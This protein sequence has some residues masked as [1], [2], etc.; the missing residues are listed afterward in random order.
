M[1][2]ERAATPNEQNYPPGIMIRKRD[3]LVVMLP[4]FEFC[5]LGIEQQLKHFILLTILL[6]ELNKMKLVLFATNA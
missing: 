4:F 2:L 6:K 3:M 5:L 1:F